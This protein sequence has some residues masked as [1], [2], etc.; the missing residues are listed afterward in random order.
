MATTTIVDR[1]TSLS[2]TPCSIATQYPICA[3]PFV[4]VHKPSFGTL[5]DAVPRYDTKQS[6]RSRNQERVC[7][8]LCASPLV[9]VV[10]QLVRCVSSEFYRRL[11]LLCTA[12]AVQLFATEF[13]RTCQSRDPVA[14]V[15]SSF[16]LSIYSSTADAKFRTVVNLI[17][18]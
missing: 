1:M 3:Q 2:V 8:A 5:C 10:W 6:E 13:T 7:F 9:V 12:A 17:C 4:H 14:R 16:S 18:R 15:G 11:I